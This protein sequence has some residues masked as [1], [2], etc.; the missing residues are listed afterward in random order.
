MSA[1]SEQPQQAQ[2]IDE[3]IIWPRENIT[4]E[5]VSKTE[6]AIRSVIEFR[7]P[8]RNYT[9]QLNGLRCWFVH[10]T[11]RQLEEIEKLDGVCHVPAR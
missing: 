6:D 10:V 8:I 2:S 5:D 4:P 1:A 7:E 11:S 9:S 3:Y